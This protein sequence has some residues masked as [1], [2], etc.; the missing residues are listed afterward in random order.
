MT[1]TSISEGSEGLEPEQKED[2]LERRGE[3]PTE[4]LAHFLIHLGGLL[5]KYGSPSQRIETVLR[6]TAD[7][8]GHVCE[9]FAVPT[10][11]WLSLVKVGGKHPVIRLSRVYDWEVDLQKL[12][13]LDE[14]FNGVADQRLS[15]PAARAR[16]LDIDR[17]GPKYPAPVIITAEAV[18]CGSAA[19]F[20]GGGWLESAVGALLG[21]LGGILVY[22]S[23]RWLQVR[24][25][26]DFLVGLLTGAVVWGATALNPELVR[27]PMLLAGIIVIVPGMTLTV[28][29]GELA[30][31][32]LVSG[33]ARFLHALMVLTSMILGLAVMGLIEHWTGVP[34]PSGALPF[35]HP[36]WLQG[37]GTV[38]GGLAFAVLFSVP[39]G[40]ILLSSCSCA[41]AWMMWTWVDLTLG[42]GAAASFSAALV[43]GIYANG[44]ARF[45]DRPSQ[46]FLLPG[47]FLLVPGTMGFLGFTEFARGDAMQGTIHL[48]NTLMNAGALIIGLILATSF[49]S[50]RKIL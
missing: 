26:V 33:G 28:A 14:V 3:T 23:S 46:I 27:K 49:L 1:T 42:S 17:V 21:V 35:E 37:L 20:F 25:L 8:F 24:L 7:D 41:V 32:Q 43:L 10:G 47:L 19:L 12:Q 50:P 30:H 29:L 39:N 15:I 11:L 31:K 5:L 44:L 2:W 18:A 40:S 16:L 38:V 36:I 4:S 22:F 45:T 48:F 34:M 6:T 13:A 9:V